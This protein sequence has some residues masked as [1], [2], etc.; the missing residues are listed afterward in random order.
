MKIYVLC[1]LV[2]FY[3]LSIG[4]LGWQN[5]DLK[6]DKLALTQKNTQLAAD[7]QTSKDQVKALNDREIENKKNEARYEKAVKELKG[8]KNGPVADVLRSAVGADLV[9]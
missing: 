7:L 3:L 4:V 6:A 8:K 1:G 5:K 2:A 9:R